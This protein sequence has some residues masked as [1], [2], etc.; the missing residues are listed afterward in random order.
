MANIYAL[1]DQIRDLSPDDRANLLAFVERDETRVS[2]QPTRED[3]EVWD[4]LE[5][6]SEQPHRALDGFLKDKNH[7]VSRRDW[8]EAVQL[9]YQFVEKAQPVRG[10]AEDH[11]ALVQLALGCLVSF[12]R[13]EQLSVT[14]R[15]II[16]QLPHLRDAFDRA[17]PGCIEAGLLHWLIRA[18][19]PQPDAAE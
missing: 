4:A 18:H 15:A 13:T 2:Y 7:G 8:Q 12:M 19:T 5:R 11:A 14:P 10:P 6:L 1:R 9:V 16:N 3:I 17:F